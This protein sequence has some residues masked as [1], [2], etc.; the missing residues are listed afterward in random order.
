[1]RFLAL[2]PLLLLAC[3]PEPAPEEPVAETPP[4]V[5]V[6]DEPAVV[7]IEE[8][9]EAPAYDDAALDAMEERDLEAAC[10]AG[11]TAACD[12]LGH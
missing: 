9:D 5:E 1:M 4:A 12:R 10:F 2:L 6:P 11:S 8:E 3:D 7:E